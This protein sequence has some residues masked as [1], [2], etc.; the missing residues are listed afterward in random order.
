MPE[1]YMVPLACVAITS[2]TTKTRNS[3]SMLTDDVSDGAH[4][5]KQR[6]DDNARRSN[7]ARA[8]G[9]LYFWWQQ[10]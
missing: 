1:T 9:L 3:L 7:K 4:N 5:T 2:T 10:V 8:R 6:A